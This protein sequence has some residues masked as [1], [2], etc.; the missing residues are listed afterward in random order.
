MS[1]IF[2]SIP[3]PK[4][5]LEYHRVLCPKAGVRVSPLCLGGMNFGDAWEEALGKV[6]KKTAFDMLNYFFDNGGNFIDT[7]NNYQYE[8]SEKWIGEWMASRKNRDQIVLATK[9]TTCYPAPE[10]NI[11]IKANYAGNHTKSLVLSVEDSLKKLQT[12]YIDLLYVHWWEFTTGVEELMQSLNHLIARGKVLYIGASDTPAWVVSKAN[13]YARNHALRP[14]SVYQGRYNCADRDLE[15]EVL[16][17][18]RSEGMALCPWGS[19][20]G[21]LFKTEEQRKVTGGRNMGGPSEKHIRISKKLEEIAKKKNTIITSVALAYVIRKQ[22]YV[23]PIVGGRKVEHL[24]GN[25]E[26][27]SLELSDEEVDEIEKESGFEIGF[28]MS[29]IFEFGGGTYNTRMTS[30][31]VGLLKFSA[32]LDSPPN[33]QAIRPHGLGK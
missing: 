12:D 15:R 10:S 18:V 3:Q 17:M 23:F 33:Q 27:L 14:F 29:F 20:G 7:S 32:K 11:R 4:S 1:S 2:G 9:F 21:G 30:A 5:L 26:A 13:E 28:P 31:D 19:L 8:Q 25:I 22:P 6:D 24:K 16:P